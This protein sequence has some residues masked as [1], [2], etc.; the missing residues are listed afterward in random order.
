MSRYSTVETETSTNQFGKKVSMI[1]KYH[2]HTPAL[3]LVDVLGVLRLKLAS[4]RRKSEDRTYSDF[5]IKFCMP[6]G[7]SHDVYMGIENLVL[8]SC[9]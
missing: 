5:P 8:S 1:R 6:V 7:N 2:N 4:V 9:R 3:A